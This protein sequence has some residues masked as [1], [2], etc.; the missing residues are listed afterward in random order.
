[1]M[2]TEKDIILKFGERVSF[3]ACWNREK[4]RER[5]I[6]GVQHFTLPPARPR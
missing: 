6:R 4:R 1:M 5:E 3:E 2:M